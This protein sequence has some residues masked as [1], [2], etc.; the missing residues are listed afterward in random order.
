SGGSPTT[1][2]R[3]SDGQEPVR[4]GAPDQSAVVVQA[5]PEV[6]ARRE[7]Q[8]TPGL[9]LGAQRA[10]APRSRV[11]EPLV[12]GDV[13]YDHRPAETTRGLELRC[14]EHSYTHT[15]PRAAPPVALRR[16]AH[17]SGRAAP[18]RC[19]LCVGLPSPCF[20]HSVVV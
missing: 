4:Q 8:V 17:T 13:V 6:P 15:K 20:Y 19:I 11:L 9:A 16:W 14:Q 2:V 5:D 12:P 18:D 1:F 10:F 3:R 7:P